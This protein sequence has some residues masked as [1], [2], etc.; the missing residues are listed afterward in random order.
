[1]PRFVEGI[2][3][4]Q[5]DRL[6]APSE[7]PPPLPQEYV[8]LRFDSQVKK[9]IGSALRVGSGKPGTAA[10]K[11]LLDNILDAAVVSPNETTIGITTLPGSSPKDSNYDR[12]RV[13]GIREEGM[14]AEGLRT[15]LTVGKSTGKGA[16]TYGI[17]SQEAIMGAGG[18]V[19]I[20][21]KRRGDR[22]E[23]KF[24]EPGY[25]DPEVP[26]DGKRP[27]QS[28]VAEDQE[29]G[30]VD[31]TIS[32]LHLHR[33]EFPGKAELV[34]E[35]SERYGPRLVEEPVKFDRRIKY[36]A[37]PRNF[38][39]AEGNPVKLHDRVVLFVSGG[40]KTEQVFPPDYQ[41]EPGYSQEL[42]IT[43]T[44][45]GEPVPFWIGEKKPE[46]KDVEPG[47]RYYVGG[48]QI[49]RGGLAGH[50]TKDPR[51]QRLVG[52]VHGDDIEDF[53]RRV[54]TLSKSA[55]S[56][57][58]HA[59]EWKRLE[60]A[61]YQAISPLIDEIRQRP[62]DA[63]VRVPKKLEQAL[64]L[65]R[66]IGDMAIAETLAVAVLTQ[67]VITAK[68]SGEAGGGQR[69]SIKKPGDKPKGREKLGIQLDGKPWAEQSGQTFPSPGSNPNIPRRR[70]GVVNAAKTMAFGKEDPRIYSVSEEG[71]RKTLLLN[72]DHDRVAHLLA[73]MDEADPLEGLKEVTWLA[74]E[75]L[76]MH[77]VAELGL[78]DP[79]LVHKLE[80]EVRHKVA[81]LM[82]QDPTTK[83]IE[84][85]LPAVT[86]KTKKKKK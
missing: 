54:L 67:G 38:I 31:I 57:N 9:A 56:I 7:P 26:Y 65:A 77:A 82:R 55:T 25:G 4:S 17:G 12:L 69:P 16:A 63:D 46:A 51:L 21:T 85:R 33:E 68:A 50:E 29:V 45:E 32:R 24:E 22:V 15:M 43:R 61:V 23:Y 10:V 35:L 8:S 37:A 78:K 34:R 70:K 41:L 81:K 13:E 28:Q 83:F 86:D 74:A 75:S 27:I 47:L 64:L 49:H 44:S 80:T 11:E 66:R 76:G 30:R 42:Q 40:R 20:V 84:T 18:N 79:D 72:S 73:L 19:V 5:V 53:K 36:G 39:D 2:Y 59:P 60:A 14:D 1:M 6:G 48:I 71:D 52:G 62:S 58:T 3:Y